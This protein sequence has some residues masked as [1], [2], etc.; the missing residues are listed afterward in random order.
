MDADQ[1]VA[2]VAAAQHGVVGRSQLLAAGV[3]GHVI[4]HR[5][6]RGLLVRVHAGVYRV[7][8]S[9]MTWHQRIMA[10]TLATGPGA[11]ASHRAAAFLH[12]LAG[13]DPRPEVAVPRARAPRPPGV[14]VHR[15]GALR[16][17]D[18]EVRDGIPR[19]RPPATI[20]G[21]SAVVSAS[22]LEAA[23]DDALVR[24]LVTTTQLE[25]RLDAAGRQGRAGAAA[26]AELLAA[27][28]ASRRWTQSAFERRLLAL[29]RDAGLPSPV[30]QFEVPLP[31]GRRA[32]LDFAWPDVRLGLEADS[33]RHHASRR[34]WG[35]DHTRNNLLTA[36]GWR[37]LP[38]T[39]QD[40]VD[41]P[42]QLVGLLLLARAV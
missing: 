10:A 33:Y 38:V 22:A 12:G 37:V 17:S 35:R 36:L 41:R 14:V 32:F 7:A 16:S 4:D 42:R 6:S 23:L 28:N 18:V 2:D 13:V 9:R 26:L 34:D 20:L 21:L 15:F 8:S 11:V 30:P 31:D 1:L 27:R 5:L 3:P 29:L 39:W 19:T 25:R 40:M 24:G